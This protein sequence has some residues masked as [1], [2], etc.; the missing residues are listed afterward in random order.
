MREP[1]PSQ[2]GLYTLAVE[3]PTCAAGGQGT[4][5]TQAP[6]RLLSLTTF[7]ALSLLDMQSRTPILASDCVCSLDFVT[8]GVP[9]NL[10]T[11]VSHV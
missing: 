7:G 4:C 2:S 5:P 9:Y 10:E 3:S 8:L 1:Q 11:S 6:R